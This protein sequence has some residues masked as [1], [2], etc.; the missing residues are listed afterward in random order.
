[1]GEKVFFTQGQESDKIGK[2]YKQENVYKPIM[3]INRYYS[4]IYQPYKLVNTPRDIF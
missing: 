2:Y 3:D 4:V 1:V